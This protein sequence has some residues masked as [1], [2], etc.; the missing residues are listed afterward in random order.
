[1]RFIYLFS[2]VT[3][4][5]KAGEG[6]ELSISRSVHGVNA[7]LEQQAPTKTEISFM[8]FSPSPQQTHTHTQATKES[9]QVNIYICKIILTTGGGVNLAPPM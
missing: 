2:L 9:F 8:L 1:M 5:I 6:F 3:K 4:E 7:A